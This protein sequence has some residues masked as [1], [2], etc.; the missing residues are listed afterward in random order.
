VVI[1]QVTPANT[2]GICTI[3]WDANQAGA[4]NDALRLNATA[5]GIAI[6][7]N[8]GTALVLGAYTATAYKIAAVMRGTGMH[9]FIKGGTFANWTYLYSTKAGVADAYPSVQAQNATS[10]FTADF[11]RVPNKLIVLYPL[12]SD[13]FTRE[14]GALGSTGGGGSEETGGDGLTWT[15]ATFAVATNKAVNSPTQ[16]VEKF[17]DGG[18][19]TWTSA[20]DLTSWTEVVSG[21]STVNREGT[22]KHGGNFALRLDIDAGANYAVAYQAGAE[23]AGTWV[24]FDWWGYASAAGK[25]PAVYVG[26][27][28]GVRDPGAVWTHFVNVLRSA[29]ANVNLVLGSTSAGGA[30]VYFDDVSAKVLTLASLFASLQTTTANVMAEV[31]VTIGEVGTQ[32]GL[33]LNLDSAAAPANFVI[34]YHDGVNVQLDKCVA[35]VYTNLISTAAA[36]SAGARLVVSKNDT[37][38]RLYYNDALVGTEQTIADAGIVSNKLHGLFCTYASN[39]LDNFVVWARGN[40]GEYDGYFD[41]YA[42]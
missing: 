8:G 33:V 10:V 13:A 15:G 19:E 42:G 34:A 20:T 29:A 18:L 38:Y 36:Y 2:G 28:S 11:V 9:W 7:P 24:V 21:T 40:G 25:K 41:K 6:V 37:K 39:S 17:T 16:G 32:A 35:G 23:P 14:D 5:A 3:G 4:I 1:F 30:S 27:V 22:V 12:A 31:A 26:S